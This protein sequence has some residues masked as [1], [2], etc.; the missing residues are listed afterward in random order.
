MCLKN[1]INTFVMFVEFRKISDEVGLPE[2][3][4]NSNLTQPDLKNGMYP[5]RRIP[6]QLEFWLLLYQ[7]PDFF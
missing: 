6:N 3:P 2:N 1:W 5:N 4:R 7:K